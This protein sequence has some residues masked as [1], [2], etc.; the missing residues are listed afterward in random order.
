MVVDDRR[1]RWHDDVLALVPQLR[2]RQLPGQRT[3]KRTMDKQERRHERIHEPILHIDD[4]RATAGFIVVAFQQ[5]AA[6]KP[7]TREVKPTRL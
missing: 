5:Q 6:F 7:T 3:Y 4:S 1:Q 2:R